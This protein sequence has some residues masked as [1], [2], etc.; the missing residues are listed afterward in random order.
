MD[1]RSERVEK[2]GGLEGKPV[3]NPPDGS[4]DEARRE[5]D[6]VRESPPER[7]LES[8]LAEIR[9]SGPAGR[10]GPAGRRDSRRDARPRRERRPFP[11]PTRRCPPS[12]ARASPGNGTFGCP[13]RRSFRSVPHVRA[14]RTST[15]ISPGPGTGSGRS[16]REARSPAPS[17]TRARIAP[18]RSSV[19][20][21]VK[22]SSS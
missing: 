5:A 11:Q 19:G 17:Q 13:R 22:Q 18:K 2:R 6:P 7:R 3:R 9:P 20:A 15:T 1:D 16:T 12:R 21:E 10:A 8:R 14:A 4:P